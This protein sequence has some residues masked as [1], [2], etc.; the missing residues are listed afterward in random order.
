MKI[1]VDGKKV[2]FT[3]IPIKYSENWNYEIEE[4]D[5]EME[6]K[7]ILP[8]SPKKW[9]YVFMI[10]LLPLFLGGAVGGGLVGGGLALIYRLSTFENTKLSI[11][12]IYL[13]VIT[14]LHG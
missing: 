5:Q 8:V 13:I 1:G 11:K 7:L 3:F 4:T 6:T 2:I 10:P 9:M 14:Y 12:I